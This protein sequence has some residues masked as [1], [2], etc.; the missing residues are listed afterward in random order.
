MADPTR[1]APIDILLIEDNPGDVRLVQEVHADAAPVIATRLHVARDGDTALD[2]LFRRGEYADAP[3]PELVFLDPHL[4][5]TT[6]DQLMAEVKGDDRLREIPIV[7]LTGCTGAV[8]LI[9]SRLPDADAFVTKPVDRRQLI[10][11]VTRFTGR[12]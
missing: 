9:E 1:V 8:D 12:D 3:R 4:P 6:G 2:F 10:S 5:Q 7:V 11:I